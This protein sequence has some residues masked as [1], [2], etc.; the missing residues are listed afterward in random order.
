LKEVER[1][2]KMGDWVA[3][4][5][6]GK[7]NGVIQEKMVS[8]YHPV[9]L[10]SNSLIPGFEEEIVGMNVDEDKTF[11]ITFP[12]D[13]GMEKELSGK[14]AEFTV[15]LH[16]VREVIKPEVDD[17]FAKEFGHDTVEDLKKALQDNL[18]QEKD[19]QAKVNLENMVLDKTLTI[20][21]TEVPDSLV[22]QE[23][24]R[25][26]HRLEHEAKNYGLTLDQYL[27]SM[28]KNAA[29]LRKEW[30]GQAE[31]N[32]K[33]GLILGEVAK[34]EELD[35]KDPEVARKSVDKLV[36]YIVEK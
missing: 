20:A 7:L 31:K 34:R 18:K 13:Y 6:Q 28:K 22:E 27:L 4:D 33:I 24:D 19:T 17:K 35:E 1:E 23:I 25:M 32:V 10:G 29:D 9:V 36:D 26:F 3:I 8:K 21:K 2:A 5:F 30:Q 11:K 14:Q 15:K 12:K 16:K